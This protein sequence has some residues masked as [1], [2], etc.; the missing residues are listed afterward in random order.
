MYNNPYSAGHF[1]LQCIVMSDKSTYISISS[2]IADYFLESIVTLDVE[3]INDWF[4]TFVIIQQ[5]QQC[6]PS[7]CQ[8]FPPYSIFT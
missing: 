1:P 8:S 3:S 4:I 5:I 2:P 6:F 7:P